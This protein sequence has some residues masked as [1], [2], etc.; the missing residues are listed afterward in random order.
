MLAVGVEPPIQAFPAGPAR[1]WRMF[2]DDTCASEATLDASPQSN[3]MDDTAW[4]IARPPRPQARLNHD[5]TVSPEFI[6]VMQETLT[7]PTPHFL[8]SI[9]TF[10]G[11][12]VAFY[13]DGVIHCPDGAAITL[14]EIACRDRPYRSGALTY[15][16]MILHGRIEARIKAARGNGL[17]TGFFLHRASP[18]QEID[19][20]ITGN[21]PQS[22]LVNVYFNPGDDG[23]TLDYGYRGSPYRVH[24]GFDATLDFHTYS[25]EWYPDHILWFVDGT[26]IHERWSWDPTPIPHL[27]MMLHANLWSPR[28]EDFAG[29]LD[30]SSIPSTAVF[31]DIAVRRF[32][33]LPSARKARKL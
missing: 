19:I 2:R 29:R 12:M 3:K 20:E 22:M 4:A 8:T 26:L 17:V 32:K 23:T 7:S 13:R 28:S 25:I 5:P 10:P 6:T 14:D 18:R 15:R 31:R 9:G 27:P 1:I 30:K 24:L 21:D 16:D 11:N 33:N